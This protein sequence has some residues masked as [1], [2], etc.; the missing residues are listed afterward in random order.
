MIG[1]DELGPSLLLGVIT[2]KPNKICLKISK[3][4]EDRKKA[5]QLGQYEILLY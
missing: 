2:F 4:Y 5:G 1:N 3:V